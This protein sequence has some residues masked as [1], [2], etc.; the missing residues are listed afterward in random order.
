ME[1]RIAFGVTRLMNICVD[2][3]YLTPFFVPA[4]ERR[5]VA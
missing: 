4:I 1:N 5:S 3:A 2:G